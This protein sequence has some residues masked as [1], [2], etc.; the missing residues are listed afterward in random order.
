MEL[1]P[2]PEFPIS[3]ILT[4]LSLDDLEL[5]K[6]LSLLLVFAYNINGFINRLFCD[7]IRPIRRNQ[8]DL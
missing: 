3:S 6:A 4:I 2:T 5:T 8:L 7:Q 1:L